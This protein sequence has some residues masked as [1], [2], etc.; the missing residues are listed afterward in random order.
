MSSTVYGAIS[1]K[2][3]EAAADTSKTAQPPA[4]STYADTLT[5][6]VPAEVLAVYEGVLVSLTIRSEENQAGALEMTI[7]NPTLLLIGSLVL[8]FVSIAFYWA[9]QQ[10]KGW[11]QPINWVRMLMPPIA[12]IIWM[13]L[14]TPSAFD[15]LWPNVDQGWRVFGAVIGALLLGL[16]T[17]WLAN[18]ADKEQPNV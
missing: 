9:G 14:Q 8:V 13:V 10:F 12:F 5:A 1:R 6:L 7:T 17:A 18:W 3:D 4:I 2:R 11:G 15:V 16:L